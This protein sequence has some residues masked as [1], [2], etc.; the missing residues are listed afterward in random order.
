MGPD[1]PPCQPRASKPS[2]KPLRASRHPVWPGLQ[3]T[4]SG[5]GKGNDSAAP[6]LKALLDAIA[7]DTLP[8]CPQACDALTAVVPIVRAHHPHSHSFEVDPDVPLWRPS[9]AQAT[10]GVEEDVAPVVAAASAT[11]LIGDAC[12]ALFAE[13]RLFYSATITDIKDVDDEVIDSS[14]DGGASAKL[15]EVTF[16]GYGSSC[17]CGGCSGGNV[18]LTQSVAR[19]RFGNVA[20]VRRQSMRPRLEPDEMCEVRRFG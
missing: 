12:D 14:S 20:W 6:P 10:D 13:D 19:P 18:S 8:S 7:S 4:G 17:L 1:L 16:I 9:F 3:A 5:N 15:Y 11:L 2:A